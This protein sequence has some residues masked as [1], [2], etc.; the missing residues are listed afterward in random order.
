MPS[1][2][3]TAFDDHHNADGHHQHVAV[4]RRIEHEGDGQHE[5]HD[6]GNQHQIPAFKAVALEGERALDAADAADHNQQ[7]EYDEQELGQ[8]IRA[9]QRIRAERRR[10]EA[11][12]QFQRV[13]NRAAR[14]DEGEDVEQTVDRDARRRQARRAAGSRGRAQRA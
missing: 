8:K 1:R 12:E 3:L 5:R 10:A 2:S 9:E 7:T 14:K 6:G 11:D 4:E 13:S